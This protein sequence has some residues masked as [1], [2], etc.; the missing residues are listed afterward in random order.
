[1]QNNQLVAQHIIMSTISLQQLDNNNYGTWKVGLT[2]NKMWLKIERKRSI[3]AKA[4]FDLISDMKY[5]T[6]LI[7]L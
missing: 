3:N 7:N 6:N 2:K 1:M 5:N 4:F